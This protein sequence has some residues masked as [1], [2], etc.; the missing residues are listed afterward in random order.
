[1]KCSK[2]DICMYKNKSKDCDM[3]ND[4]LFCSYRIPEN[5]AVHSPKHYTSGGI[6]CKDAIKAALS[7]EEF[8]GWIK[9]NIIKYI[10]RERLKNG[11]EDIRK[12]DKYM[13]WLIE[14]IEK[15]DK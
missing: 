2:K 5:D 15:K 8:K 10:F 9:G 12:A 4:E 7:P 1:M 6:E 11:D 3:P 14:E 13:D